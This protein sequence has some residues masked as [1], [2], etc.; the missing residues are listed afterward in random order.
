MRSPHPWA[1]A[2][3]VVLI[4]VMLSDAIGTLIVTQGRTSAWRP[5]RLWYQGT[6]RLFRA[7]AARAPSQVADMTLNVYPALS[8][9][10]L[11]VLWLAGLMLGWSLV[12][13]GLGEQI[14]GAGD[15]GAIVYYAGTTL[16]TPA[17]GTARAVP[18][19]ML[20]LVETLTG[21]GTV[22]LLISYLPALYGAYSRREARLLTLDDP[23]GARLTPVRIMA[24]HSGDQ[25]LE[26]LYRFFGEWEMWTA[27]VLESHVSYPML[28][29][30]RSQHAGQSWVTA[31][32]V[33]TDAATLACAC[34]EGA[35]NREP[36]FLYRRGRRA[37]LEIAERIH[38]PES[39]GESWLTL[40]NFD[41]AWN[42]LVGLGLPLRAKAD[43]WERL[44]ELRATYGDRLENL[45]DFLLAPRGFWGH[46]AEETV[47]G[48]VARASAEARMR[49]RGGRSVGSAGARLEPPTEG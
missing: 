33:I 20:S 49:A 47:A 35:D 39:A 28:A 32:G 8:L 31:L 36:Y 6:W 27:E 45:I 46:S 40:A 4:I 10:G 1:V 25:N 13:W 29:V 7:V 21:L 44:Q 48:E 18:V 15:F 14:A 19:R 5:T 34:I 3:G 37:V 12:Y 43:A 23:T 38:A 24:I 16:L 17:F 30:F 26:L 2:L 41:A 22:A 42:I 9:L 11:L